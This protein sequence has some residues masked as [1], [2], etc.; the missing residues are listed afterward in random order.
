MKY[1][2]IIITLV[3]ITNTAISQQKVTLNLREQSATTLLQ[4]VARQS[5]LSI[6]FLPGETDT[7]QVSVTCKDA[8]PVKVIEDAIAETSLRMTVFENELYILTNKTIV[9]NLPAYL[10]SLNN[11]ESTLDEP[12]IVSPDRGKKQVASSEYKLYEI[13]QPGANSS[14]TLSGKVIHFNTGETVAGA[15]IT[16]DNGATGTTTDRNG[17]YSL[18]LKPGFHELDIAS[19]GIKNT[20]RKIRIHSDGVL[21]I[22]TEEEIYLME[23]LTILSSRLNKV[24]ETSMGVE[25]FK[26]KDIKNIPTAFGEVDV[27]KAVLA[28]PGVKSTGEVASGYNVRGS[29][30][31]Q[32]LILLDHSTIFNPTHLFGMLSVFNPDL[33][34]SMELYMSN[35]P[36]KYGGRIASVLD[37]SSKTGNSKEF[38]GSASLGLL[39]SRVALEGPL[40]SDKTTFTL[41]ARTSNSDWILDLIPEGSGYNNGS[42]GFYD[43][44]TGLQHKIDALNTLNL[45]AYFSR[46]RFSFEIDE[47]FSYQNLNLSAEWR[48]VVS[49]ELIANYIAGYDSYSNKIANTTDS[50]VAYE[51]NTDIR[52]VHAKADFDY[53]PVHNHLMNFGMSIN[54]ISLQPGNMQPYDATSMVVPNQLQNERAIE[55][56]LYFNEEWIVMPELSISAG[57]RYSLYQLLGP[58]TYYTYSEGFLPSVSTVND[59]VDF[60]GLFAKSYHGPEFRL[61]MRYSITDDLSVK[62][63]FNTMRQN[64]HKISNSTVMS[65]TD[66]WKLS[67]RHIAPQ[68]GI[69]IAWGIYKNL[70]NNTL[71]ASIEMYYKTTDDYLDYRS[72]AQLIMNK[73]IE[74][75][76]VSTQGRAYGVELALKKPGG[77][78][79]GWISYTYARTMLRQSDPLISNPVNKGDWYP[80]DFDKPH[81]FKLVGNYK[82]THRY[83]IS[84]NVYYSTGRPIT[85]P[86]AK[87]KFAGG[88]YI[89]YSDRNSQRIPDYFRMDASFNIEPSHNLTLLTHSTI[90]IGVYNITGRDN[91]YSVYYKLQQGRLRGYQLS[92]FAVAIPYISYNIKF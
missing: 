81:D 66:T 19:M 37:V 24:K 20:K 1:I 4:E 32:N 90:S 41:G 33:V 16:I 35:I 52:Q 56:A 62:A 64:I 58:K 89:Y 67:D 70:M 48:H 51:L 84:T 30:S 78:L 65:P 29:A 73:H 36:A 18:T 74:T 39:S 38:S 44:N 13:G 27:L 79:N 86:I 53:F 25:R 31:D 72:G 88:D 87:Y 6:Y 61:S 21:D 34:E 46:D 80:A 82:F 60:K 91:V 3:L 28:L 47:Q 22:E 92:I 12:S 14:A 23:E 50:F 8:H 9:T 15:T 77:K 5:G 83:S 59:T 68:T 45:H 75:E 43:V 55:T 7:V 2:F 10:A 63:G 54:G 40:F 85:L 69:Q 26:M 42:A 17:N 57:L 71:N 11:D 76:V 49:P